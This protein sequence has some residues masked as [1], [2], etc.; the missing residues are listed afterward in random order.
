[1]AGGT[2]RAEV[3][4]VGA[5]M[6]GSAAAKYCARQGA[7]TVLVGPSEPDCRARTALGEF[8]A[9]ADE[10]RIARRLGW[11]EVWGALDAR[12][13]ARYRDIEVESG[14]GFFHECGALALMAGSL[15]ERT[16]RMLRAGSE[17]GVVVERLSEAGLR[18]DFPDLGALP[19]AG[20][21]EGLLERKDAG[22]L[23]PRRLVAAQR[24]LAVGAG[25]RLVDGTVAEIDQPRG[26]R[27]RV[28]TNDGRHLIEAD[29]VLIAAGS[30][31]NHTG[32]LPQGHT[33]DLQVFTEPNLLL[34]LDDQALRRL[35][36]L[37]TVVTIDPED[38]GSANLSAYLIPPLRYPD[39]KW[40]VRVGPAMQPIVRQLHT[41]EQVQAWYARQQLAPDQSAFLKRM[42]GILLPGLK[43]VSVRSACCVVDKTASRFPYI[44][45]YGD[46]ECLT[47]AVG[48]NGHGARGSDE[49]GRLAAD[50]VLDRPWD[51]PV[52]REAFVPVAASPAA[53]HDDDHDHPCYLRPPFGLC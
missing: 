17:A 37:P 33:L 49:I 5:G 42:A 30:L 44:G 21:V 36:D 32:T 18:R 13:T 43:P 3:A 23:N 1:M 28:R 6:F 46:R 29:K 24:R 19:L 51:F 12:S 7:D 26:G 38:S 2:V 41:A 31:I 27:W 47:V 45:R 22:H 15:R 39:G 20:G 53:D 4:V 48:G 34:E 50:V 16:G 25:A 9:W 11:D 40:Y 8:G 10:S 35:R 52:P 14:I